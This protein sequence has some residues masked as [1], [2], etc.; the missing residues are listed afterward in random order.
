M[1]VFTLQARRRTIFVLGSLVVMTLALLGRLLDLQI[2][3]HSVLTARAQERLMVKIPLYPR[4]GH[5]FDSWG[6]PLVYNEQGYVLWV[7]GPR[8]EAEE[9]THRLLRDISRLDA[10]STERYLD[11]EG[12]QFVLWTRWLEP[13]Q[14]EALEDYIEAEA[15]SGVYLET[16]PRRVYPYGNLLSPVLGHLQ[17]MGAQDARHAT[18]YLAVGGV[19]NYYDNILRGTS[20]WI[21]MEQDKYS[22]R[23]PIGPYEELLPQEGGNITL[24]L[25]LNIQYQA[26]RLL[27]TAIADWNARRG[28]VLVMNPQTGAILAMASYPTYDPSDIDGCLADPTCEEM[29]N[30]YPNPITGLPYEP[31]STFKIVTMAI[32]LEEHVV[33]PDSSFQCAGQTVVGGELIRNWNGLGHGTETMSEVLLHSCNVGAIHVATR[34]G[35]E[36]YYEHIVELGFGQLSGVDIAGERPGQIRTPDLPDWSI[37]DLATNAFGQSIS[38][39]PLQLATAVSAVANGGDLM[40]PYVVQA[41]ERN[42]VISETRP[43][44]RA[45]AFHDEVCRDVTEMLVAIGQIKGEN[46]GPIARGYRVALKTGTS[47]IPIPGGYDPHRSIASAIGYAPADDP[48][49]LILVRIE[50]NDTVW[51]EHTAVPVFRDLTRYLL[52]YLRLPP[53]GSGSTP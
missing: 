38:L 35:P 28:D 1:S 43:I 42:G 6:R 30:V 53:T 10:E 49:F 27:T 19:E 12:E 37:S 47:Q 22:S 25:D 29:L 52:N 20:G 45:R 5:L 21:S 44:V 13:Y 41:V 8:L 3:R 24:T 34:V 16:E 48:Q 46:G 17:D 7:D 31:G 2:L 26:Y 40:Q 51:G 33:R 15:L 9:S 4:R 14:L 32:G 50:G 36:A 18:G 23:I 11:G 39:T